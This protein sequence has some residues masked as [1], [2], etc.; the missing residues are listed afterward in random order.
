MYSEAI[1]GVGNVV[2][3]TG[4]I[5]KPLSNQTFLEAY[6]IFFFF[7]LKKL[8]STAGAFCVGLKRSIS[9]SMPLLPAAFTGHIEGWNLVLHRT[10]SDGLDT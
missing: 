1:T 8:A 2:V 7:F 9:P 4:D 6:M 5:S 3:L 10:V